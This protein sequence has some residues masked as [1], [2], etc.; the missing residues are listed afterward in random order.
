[1]EVE[2]STK[3]WHF[4]KVKELYLKQWLDHYNICIDQ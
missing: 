1:M 2:F 4:A 3:E